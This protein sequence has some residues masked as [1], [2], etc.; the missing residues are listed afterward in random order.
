MANKVMIVMGSD[1]DFPI[2]EGCFKLLKQ[3][4]VEFEANVASAHRTP[5][6]ATKLAKEAKD[7]GFKVIIAAAGLAAHLGGVLAANTTLPVI[8]VPVKGGALNGVD[9]LYATVQMPTGIPVATVAIDGGTNAAILAIQIL[10]LS[11]E[12][13]AEQFADYKANLASSV[14]KKDKALKEKILGMED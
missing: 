8:G 1:S 11:D 4:G 5:E 7:N 9:A 2:M 6:R 13:L 12:R 14:D 10:A 3:F